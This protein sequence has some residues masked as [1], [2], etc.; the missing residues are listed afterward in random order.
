MAGDG[1]LRGVREDRYPPLLLRG[2]RGPDV[3]EVR[4]REHERRDVRRAA[5]QRLEGL[6]QERPRGREARVDEGDAPALLHEVAVHPGVGEAMHAGTDVARE[7]RAG[8]TEAA[9]HA[10]TVGGATASPLR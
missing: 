9:G 3:V 10:R 5:G 1:P 4:V 7:D 6:P 8:T 2:E